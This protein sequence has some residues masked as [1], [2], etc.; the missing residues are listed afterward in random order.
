MNRMAEIRPR[1]DPVHR[2]DPDQLERLL[3]PERR[4]GQDPEAILDALGLQPGMVAADIGSGPGF[5]TLPMANRVGP[6]GK[7]FAIDVEPRMI[8]RLLERSAEGGVGNI[9]ALLSLG[10]SLPLP[11]G[12]I[13]AALMVNVLHE[14]EDRGSIL[15]QVANALRP[16][17]VLAVVEWKKERTESGPPSQIR[18]GPT[19]LEVLLGEAGYKAV[20]PFDVGPH[21]YG[22][23][24]GKPGR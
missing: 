9:E 13:D 17:G 24:A 2:F 20:T 3:N 23:R 4:Q 8:E 19:E 22:L 15:R 16:G 5:F 18:L 21:H 14:L 7:V 6:S 12:G 10:G 1:G 11:D